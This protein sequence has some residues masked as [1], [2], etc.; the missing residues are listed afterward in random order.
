M[1]KIEKKPPSGDMRHGW[2]FVYEHERLSKVEAHFASLK[3]RLPPRWHGRIQ[4]PGVN[5]LFYSDPSPPPTIPACV[6]PVG[7]AQP[8]PNQSSS[9]GCVPVPT[10]GSIADAAQQDDDLYDNDDYGTFI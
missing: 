10:P 3:S 6:G 2:V 5:I 9:P 7:G 4:G 8:Q 1:F